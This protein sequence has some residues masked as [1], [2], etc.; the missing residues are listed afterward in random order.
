[1][2]RTHLTGG[3]GQANNKQILY[4]MRN[5]SRVSKKFVVFNSTNFVGCA[6]RRKEDKTKINSYL[7][8]YYEYE[9]LHCIYIAVC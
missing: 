4:N 3:K 2:T 8:V 1:M 5:L 6:T 7:N 9:Q